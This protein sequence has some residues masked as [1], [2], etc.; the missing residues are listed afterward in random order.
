MH[1]GT[2]LAPDIV[3]RQLQLSSGYNH[4]EGW[5]ST[6]GSKWKPLTNICCKVMVNFRS[7]SQECIACQQDCLGELIKKKRTLNGILLLIFC[8][9]SVSHIQPNSLKQRS[10][11]TDGEK[12]CKIRVPGTQVEKTK[13]C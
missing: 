10:A 5:K 8:N 9:Y 11:W 6:S 13:Q 3:V 12:P 7:Q 2:Q 1:K 4:V